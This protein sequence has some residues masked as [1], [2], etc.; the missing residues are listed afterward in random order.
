MG[1]SWFSPGFD[2][3]TSSTRAENARAAQPTDLAQAE[4]DENHH[5]Q[6]ALEALTTESVEPCTR[7]GCTRFSWLGPLP[8]VLPLLPAPVDR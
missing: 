6:D 3:H 2:D 7:R 1:G 4:P 5:I 8:Y